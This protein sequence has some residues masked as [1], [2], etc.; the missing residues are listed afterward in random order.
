MMRPQSRRK[1]LAI[2]LLMTLVLAACAGGNDEAAEVQEGGPESDVTLTFWNGFTG[3]DRPALETLVDRFNEEQDKIEIEMEIMPWD[4]FF[5]KILPSLA[6]DEGPDIAAMATEQIPQYAAKGVFAPLDELYDENILDT[7]ALVGPAVDATEF[8]GQ[9]YGVPMNFTTL[10]LYWNKDMF[11]EAGLD[12]EQPPTTWEEWAEYAVK[13]TKDENGDG[14][15][16]QYGYAIADH[17]TIPMWPILIWGNGGEIVAEDGSQAMLDDPATIEAV[18]YWSDLVVNQKISP[19]GLAGAD[20]DKLFLSKKAAMEVVGPWMTTGF[21]DAGIDFGLAMVPAGPEQQVTLGTSVA[22][23]LNSKADADT[24]AAAYEFFKFWNSEE[25][26]IYWAVNSG[27]PPTRTDIDSS[28]LGENPYVGEFAKYAEQSKFYLPGIPNFT[29]VNTNN[30]EPA[31]QKILNGE[32]TPEEVLTST[33]EQIE[34]V[35]G[36]E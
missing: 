18:E 34:S 16:E 21:E 19:V 27:F 4:V 20:A 33:D 8:E 7:E 12:P 17:E 13:L 32:G 35:L 15:P 9:H 22:M 10:L 23:V 26:Q 2:A 25:S 36:Q 5:Q 28:Q 29:E 1:L 6:S 24:K 3:P 14:K 31:I 11:R 30:F